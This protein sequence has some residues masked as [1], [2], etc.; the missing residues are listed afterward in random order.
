MLFDFHPQI[1]NRKRK[2]VGSRRSFAQPKWNSRR[3][4]FCIL[5]PNDPG[6]HAQDSPRCVSELKNVSSETFDGEIFVDCAH[7]NFRWLEN[8]SI[9]GVIRNSSA[10]GQRG[11]SG[12]TPSAQTMI[13]PI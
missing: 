13:N 4:T 5:H 3:L 8:H 11:D 10:G 9:I 2:L 7:E 12:S 1:G 6:I